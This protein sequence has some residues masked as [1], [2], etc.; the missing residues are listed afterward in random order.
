[1]RVAPIPLYAAVDSRMDVEEAALLAGE[2]AKITHQ[3]PLGYIPAALMAHIIYR[4]AQDEAPTLAALK[5]YVIEGMEALE[6][7]LFRLSKPR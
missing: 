2:A 7:L 4:L 1:M 3:N 5:Q 6:K